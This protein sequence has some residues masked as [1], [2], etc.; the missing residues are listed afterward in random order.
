MSRLIK[1]SL[2]MLVVFLGSVVVHG[3]DTDKTY[4]EFLKNT[5]NRHDKKLNGFLKAELHLFI[6]LYPNSDYAGEASYLLAQ[7][8]IDSR[9]EN[10][11]FAV[12]MKTLYLYPGAAMNTAVSAE[13]QRIIATNG[14]FKHKQ[15]ELRKIIDGEFGTGPR[16]DRYYSYLKFLR[17]LDDKKL[18]DWTLGEYYYF[19]ERFKDDSRIEQIHRWVAD[20]YAAKG[21]AEAAVAGYQEY[22]QLFPVNKNLPYVIINR[23][24]V[25]NEEL[26]EYALASSLLTQV[27]DNYPNTG[28]ASTALY[29]RAGIKADR[30]RDYSGAIA[31]YRLLATEHPDNN[32]A[33]DAL[34][35]I[36]KLNA[37]RLKAYRAAIDVYN[38]IV[39]KYP[40]SPRGAEAL[41][42][43]AELYMKID[44]YFQAAKQ[45]ARVAEVYPENTEAPALLYEAGE[46]ALGK[47]K[48]YQQAKTFYSQVA[49]KYPASDYAV[50]ARQKVERINEKLGQQ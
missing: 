39:E 26:K 15:E 50:K 28:Y 42:N 10:E 41:K 5:Y 35:E 11:A 40:D 29:S 16:E 6:E 34:F 20:M 36:A 47:M 9:D 23:A 33:V 30:F 31:D 8:Y 17:D 22:E 12:L 25:L 3:E 37:D 48:D 43:S 49:E 7:N 38:E 32:K 13:A 21:D 19:I 24:N 46:I 27:I 18:Y 1:I 45:Y 2:V 14:S 44:D 4:F